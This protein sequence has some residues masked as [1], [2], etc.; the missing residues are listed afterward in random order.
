MSDYPAWIKDTVHLK[1]PITAESFRCFARD[2][3]V[4]ETKAHVIDLID[5]QIINNDLI[6]TLP[7]EHGEI[8]RDVEQD[9]L[10]LAVVERYGKT[11][12]V[13]AA[14]NTYYRSPARRR[15]KRTRRRSRLRPARSRR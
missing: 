9:I 8:Q 4:K 15:G 7:V 2:P 3:Q 5:V 1:Q 6:R 14:E 13:V 12:A 11:G 10:K